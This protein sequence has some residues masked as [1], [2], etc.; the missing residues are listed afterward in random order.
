MNHGI[1]DLVD[2]LLISVRA[3]FGFSFGDGKEVVISTLEE[4]EEVASVVET[5]GR[6]AD[7][8]RAVTSAAVSPTI[9][10]AIETRLSSL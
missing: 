2:F 3:E 6:G 1:N 5:L 9:V 8:S 10:D 4:V 7:W